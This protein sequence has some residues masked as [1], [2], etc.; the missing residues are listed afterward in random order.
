MTVGICANECPL[1]A[2]GLGSTVMTYNI[3]ELEEGRV[4]VIG[5]SIPR[6]E[7]ARLLAGFGRF[8][9]DLD[10]AGQIY[11]RVVR[12]PVAHARLL[13]IDTAAAQRARGV[14]RVL[15][16]A[17]LDRVWRIPVRISPA[18]CD[19]TGF[20]QPVLAINRLRYVGEPVAVVL[21][22]D[23]YLAED[24]V[25]RVIV[26]YQELAVVLDVAE[27]A[28][29]LPLH[30]AGHEAVA[31]A[32]G[33]GDIDE[34][35]HGAAEVVT[36]D[37][38]V[39]RHSA[40][41]LEPRSL[42]A[43]Y[44]RGTHRVDV[45]GSTKVP[46]FNRSVLASML[47]LREH[48]LHF[49]VVDVGGGFGVRGEFY[50]EDFLVP[51]ASRVTGRPVKWTE[52]RYEHLV[53]VNH[54]REQ[55]H[56]IS[57]AFDADGRIR[58]LRDDIV[59]DN[60]AYVR[61]HGVTVPELTIAMLPG[62]YL[63]PSYSGKIR[64]VLTNKTPCG[65]Y[66]APGRYEGTFA[67]EHLLDV[68]ASRLNIDPA[69]LRRR[70]LLTA[71]DLP[72]I[73]PITALGTEMVLDAGDYPRLFQKA[74]DFVRES[75]WQ[76]LVDDYRADGRLVGLGLAVFLEKSG[77]GPYETA[78]VTVH[79]DGTVRVASGGTS[80]GQGIETV[81]AQIAADVLEV[82]PEL[83]E[84]IN[85]D[86]GLQPYGLGSW[87]SRSTVVAGSAVHRAANATAHRA[88]EMASR[89]LEAP[90]GDLEL[91]DGTVQVS[92]DPSA[93]VTLAEVAAACL[94]GSAHLASD[95]PA[96]LSAR[97]RFEVAHMT[98]PYGVHA[99][100]VEVDP[101]RT[102]WVVRSIRPSLRASSSAERCKAW[103]A[104]S[105]SSSTTT[106]RGSRWPP[107]LWTIFCRPHL[108]FVG[109]RPWSPRTHRRPATR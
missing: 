11:L 100:V 21:A 23:P 65:T 29:V 22:D 10:L 28:E 41:P 60:G 47:G 39:G 44:D 97:R 59:H 85:G 17:D 69:E 70:N 18:G 43:S 83:V 27:V 101:R 16:A 33:Y 107:A 2:V 42:L 95:E 91:V 64:V 51:W 104:Q 40:V 79:P 4:S 26:A 46:H 54:S 106:P 88:K 55:R 103:A 36:L 78:D 61:T 45:W 87:A 20:L 98:Y 5:R 14:I 7:D 15:T 67:R 62:P 82:D 94:P 56:H 81:L 73:R 75:G 24:A 32:F 89:M 30:D 71:T 52:D 50:P 102:R 9:D 37:L 109:C 13:S 12:S 84:V 53:A 93:A 105:S 31:M 57:A 90:I 25:E 68:A 77:L 19:L 34:A 74:T 92:G 1:T 63:V 76:A 3:C 108:R 48:Q 66:R 49:H 96:G 72:H 80:L 58:G 6:H 8:A 99:A 35:F 86:T 38:K